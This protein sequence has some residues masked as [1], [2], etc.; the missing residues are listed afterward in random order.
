MQS[1][2]RSK[3]TYFYLLLLCSIGIGLQIVLYKI[4]IIALLLQW[5]ISAGFKQKMIKLRENNLAVGMISLYFLYTLSLLWSDNI[6]FGLNDLFLKS[7][8]LILSLIIASQESLIKKQIN[9]ILLSFALSS[10]ILNIY[11]LTDACISYMHTEELNEFFYRKF[12]IIL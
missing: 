9:Q 11:C 7:P 5:L 12:N 10:F 1:L 6:E 8:I 3:Q 2:I 4:A